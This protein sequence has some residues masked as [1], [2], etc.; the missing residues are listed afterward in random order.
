[1]KFISAIMA[2]TANVAAQSVASLKTDAGYDDF[3]FGGFQ[4]FNEVLEDISPK[5]TEISIEERD[6]YTWDSATDIS[7]VLDRSDIEVVEVEP[8][9][10]IVFRLKLDDDF[11]DNWMVLNNFELDNVGFVDA[12]PYGGKFR[13]AYAIFFPCDSQHKQDFLDE[14]YAEFGLRVVHD[15]SLNA[16]L[17][18]GY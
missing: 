12:I 11:E 1:M 5:I 3:T 13:G 17:S 9:E 6:F 16:D 15:F 7:E 14:E 10:M 8:C 2:L 18:D 4:E